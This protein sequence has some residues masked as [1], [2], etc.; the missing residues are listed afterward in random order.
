MT[1]TEGLCVLHIHK[2]ALSPAEAEALSVAEA[3]ANFSAEELSAVGG[4]L[5][6]FVFART[7]SCFSKL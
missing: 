7:K 5:W 4:W 1:W 2:R 6:A 3:E